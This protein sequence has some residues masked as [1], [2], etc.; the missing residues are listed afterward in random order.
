VSLWCWVWALALAADQVSPEQR[1]DRRAAARFHQPQDPYRILDVSAYTLDRGEARVGPWAVA[2]GVTPWL[3]VGTRLPLLVTGV[4][5]LHAKLHVV[6]RGPVDIAI[7][8]EGAYA[9]SPGLL[10]PV[11]RQV[12]F[13]EG[14]EDLWTIGAGATVSVRALPPWTVHFTLHGAHAAANVGVDLAE[15]PSID[16][17]GTSINPQ[18]SPFAS[19]QILL[20]RFATDLRLNRRDSL[21]LQGQVSPFVRAGLLGD[22]E[23]E[24]LGSVDLGL[25]W[26]DP[27]AARDSWAAT[28]SWELHFQNLDLRLGAG[29][30]A[31]PGYWTVQA[32]D[33][34]ARFGGP[35]R[36]ADREATAALRQHGATPAG[37]WIHFRDVPDPVVGA[38]AAAPALAC[39]RGS[40]LRG[41]SPPA[42]FALECV[43]EAAATLR[44]GPA[45]S[46]RGDG[47]LLAEGEYREGL[48]H[49]LWRSWHSGGGLESEGE[50]VLGER[51]GS[52]AFFFPEGALER[53]GSFELGEEVGEWVFGRA[54]GTLELRGSFVQG[55]RDGLWL[56]YGVDGVVESETEYRAGRVLRFVPLR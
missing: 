42:G 37:G 32:L 35:A 7:F 45:R 8:V 11:L 40:V 3:Q 50:Y 26:Q 2:V 46:W 48:R 43:R 55:Q 22:A 56:R 39:P 19:A 30:S 20:V 9:P 24:G 36:R 14:Y 28:L 25:A 15:L 4:A 38:E 41:A 18:L 51:H 27:N 12:G 1:E 34:A 49:G 53:R 13:L 5:D 44:H 33:V 52:W 10:T 31:I 6:R 29:W 21:I 23:I 54:D 16:V 47:S 17:D